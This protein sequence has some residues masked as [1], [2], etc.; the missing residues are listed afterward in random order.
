MT[1]EY[2]SSCGV[3]CFGDTKCMAV[4]RFGD[5]KMIYIC[6]KCEKKNIKNLRVHDSKKQ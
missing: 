6:E 5:N 4:Q 3:A 2:C 1:L